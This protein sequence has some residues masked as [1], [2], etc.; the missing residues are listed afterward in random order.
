MIFYFSGTGNSEH[1]ATALSTHTSE[2]RISMSEATLS[3]NE[4]FSVMPGERIGF[5]FPVYWYSMPTLVER[6]I[7]QINITWTEEPYVY[8]VVTYGMA[9]GHVMTGLAQTLEQK[10][11]TLSGRFGVRMVDNYIIASPMPSEEK[12]QEINLAAEADIQA[13]A[14]RIARKEKATS[15]RK[16]PLAVVTPLTGY[17]YRRT[18][19]TKKFRS[20]DAC[21]GCGLCLRHCPCGA[22]RINDG[23]PVWAGPCTFCLKCLH[24]CPNEAIQY[25][26]STNQR[27][28]YCYQQL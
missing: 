7:R 27:K 12:Q 16:G 25:G 5:V 9:A 4:T 18:D 2:K 8:S 11:L 23:R 26:R 22:I 17:A 20:T 28:K 14:N 24:A 13:F 15:L 19:H 10:G 21:S 3:G 1:V 6:F